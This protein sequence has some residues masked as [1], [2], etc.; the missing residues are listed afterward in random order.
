MQRTFNNGDKEETAAAEDVAQDAV[1]EIVKDDVQDA[2]EVQP[3][4]EGS[5]TTEEAPV[6]EPLA[7]AA[8]VSG[9]EKAK[10]EEAPLT[11]A[12]EGLD[13]PTQDT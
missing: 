10:E 3:E 12:M 7:S 6:E 1:Q 2:A 4:A 5:T 9:E 8:P 13:L 11:A